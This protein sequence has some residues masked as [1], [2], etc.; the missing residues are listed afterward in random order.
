MAATVRALNASDFRKFSII[1]NNYYE[2]NY[3]A[4]NKIV[5]EDAVPKFSSEVY[6][7]KRRRG[8]CAMFKLCAPTFNFVLAGSNA[9]LLWKILGIGKD[10]Q[11]M[12]LT[13]SHVFDKEQQQFIHIDDA[14]ESGSYLYGAQIAKFFIDEFQFGPAIEHCIYSALADGISQSKDPRDIFS[15]N[16]NGEGDLVAGD[17][18]VTYDEA[19]LIN[20][21]KRTVAR[22]EFFPRIRKKLLGNGDSRFSYLVNIPRDKSSLYGM[23]NENIVVIPSEMRPPMGS[24]E[25]RLTKRY[26]A[27]LKYNMNLSLLLNTATPKILRNAY[28]DLEKSVEQLQYKLSDVPGVSADDR[29]ILERIKGKQGQ[30]R[31]CNLGKRQDYSGRAVVCVDPFLPLDT[32]RVPRHMLAKLYQ[33]YAVPKIVKNIKANQYRREHGMQTDSRYENINLAHLDNARTQ[34]EITKLIEQEKVLD[35]VPVIIGRQPTLHRQSTQA[36]W[37]IPTDGTAIEMNP[38]ACPGYNMDFDGDQAYILVPQT[39]AAVQEVANLILITQNLF[40]SKDGSLTTMPRMDMLYGLYMCTRDSYTRNGP[41]VASFE[42]FEDARQAIMHNKVHVEAMC[43]VEGQTMS[44]GDAAFMACFP[45]GMISPRGSGGER[46]LKQVNK[47]T[48]GKYIGY[49]L[50]DPT[51]AIGKKTHST[52]T[53]SGV[54]N[55]LVELGFK[56]AKIYIPNL[57]MLQPSFKNT[58][59]ESALQEFHKDV[60]DIEFYYDLGLETKEHYTFLYEERLAKLTSHYEK[61]LVSQLEDD[62]G[63]KLLIDSGARGTNSNM[64]MSFGIKGR[65]SKND[66]EAFDAIIEN[67]YNTQLTPMEHLVD[68]FGSR[69]GMIDKSLKT[70]DTGYLSRQMW[71]TTQGMHISCED[72][73]T[74]DGISV[75]KVFLRNFSNEEDS[76]KMDQD[77]IELFAYAI[78]GRYIAGTDEFVTAER[79]KQL[80]NDPNV[81]TIKMRSPIKCKKPCCAKCYGT[82]WAIHEKTIPGTEQGIIS[83]QS[84][85]ESLTQTTLNN[86][87]KGGIVNLNNVTS[88]FDKLSSYMSRTSIAKKSAKGTYSGYD[89]CA[90]DTGKVNVR[91]AKDVN[92]KVISIEG[93]NKSITVPKSLAV[94]DTVQQGEGISIAHGDYDLE[95]LLQFA[96]IETAQTYLAFK[97]YSLF[98]STVSIKMIHFEVLVAEMT[99]HMIIATNRSDLMVGQYCTTTELYRGSTDGTV[100]S[101]TLIGVDAILTRSMEAFDGLIMERQCEGISRAC[102]LNLHDSFTKPINRIVFGETVLSGSAHPGYMERRTRNIE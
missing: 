62:N 71:H 40:L 11:Q 5:S 28:M 73:G 76:A 70:G 44:A 53:I 52:S 99:R 24:A 67:S 39:E 89:P 88:V 101:S 86:F 97:L 22:E 15:I 65:V 35:K 90:W 37:A 1:G 50:E 3:D 49:L 79:A 85:G 72:C 31:R 9:S 75:N 93:S 36:F 33:S 8:T 14:P 2:D 19:E 47:K 74:T 46:E 78:E 68:A 18:Y 92:Y 32:V 29:S 64:S 13:M 94:K 63:Y 58:R 57:S 25:H 34:R 26:A 10:E 7:S 17:Y 82:D 102:A 51:M 69:Q 4:L 56:T 91:M 6:M 21:L 66:V 20:G 80:A 95:E 98:K 59:D 42:C 55:N 54:L 81:R 77:A 45:T 100:Y 60:A 43:T 16:T 12:M 23:L 30:V 83:A 96:G 87:H 38:L 27:V 84:L 41:V 48:I 61:N